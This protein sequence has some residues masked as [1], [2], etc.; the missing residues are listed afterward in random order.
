MTRAISAAVGVVLFA[1]A[2]ITSAAPF[3][4][5]VEI[6]GG[7]SLYMECRGSGAPTVILE[8]GLRTR[9][10]I[11]STK[12]VPGQPLTVFGRVSKLTRVCEYDRP[13]TI[14]FDR[15]L[16]RSDPVAM[17]RTAAETVDD[18]QATLSAARIRGPI[19]LVGHSMGG[20]IVRLYA[21][22]HPRRVAGMVEVDALAERMQHLL[23]PDR[24]AQYAALNSGPLSGLESYELERIDFA[25]SFAQMRR[26][27]RRSPPAE[28]PLIVVSK[29]LPFG[30]SPELGP[31]FERDI[32][33]AWDGSQRWLAA[34][35]GDAR[36]WI[37]ARSGHY[38][39]LDQPRIVVRAVRRVVHEAR[40]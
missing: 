18:L 3:A 32:E 30:I 16:S 6:G 26:A 15:A 20:L 13:G 33:R 21:A 29:A 34:L 14:T 19:V 39:M 36:R 7:R 4:G 11:W 28:I 2:S 8:A 5:D 31:E 40:R 9:G 23:S 1:S 35:R 17:P 12:S 27:E 10:D 37:A 24:F 22:T 25:R 38:A